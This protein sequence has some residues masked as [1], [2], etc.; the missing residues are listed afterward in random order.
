MKRAIVEGWRETRESNGWVPYG[1]DFLKGERTDEPNA[2]GYILRQAATFWAWV[3]YYRHSGD[4]RDLEPTREA[5]TLLDRHSLPIGKSRF[6]AGL[7][8]TRILSVPAGRLTLTTAL[9]KLGLL[10]DPSGAGK[11]VSADGQY[12]TVWL[13]ATALA[14]LTE[15]AYRQASGDDS[16]AGI[17]A[18][19]RDGLLALRIPG[20]GF[21]ESPVSID[22]SDYFNGEAW[23]AL[24]VYANLFRE[25]EIV[26]RALVDLDQ[27][28]MGHY[29]R[30]W[31]TTFYQWGAM[32]AAQRWRTTGDARYVEYLQQQTDV[33]LQ[34][35]SG[36]IGENLNACAPMEGLAITQGVLM[37]LG[38]EQ[39]DLAQRVAAMLDRETMKLPRFQIRPGQKQLP[40]GGDA[41]LYAPRL[42][43]FAGA[44][45]FDAQRPVVRV[46]GAQ[47]CLSALM[48]VD[49]NERRAWPR[50]PRT[51]AK[52]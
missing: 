12:A 14:L 18:A 34:R 17:R 1:F 6:Q 30:N 2:P 50:R 11:V 31:S 22:D 3:R 47:H 38:R 25:D 23:L 36:R 15:L 32:A 16:F 33:F 28:V 20:G 43:D 35:F 37:E 24:A 44:L 41:M 42:A 39:S 51:P 4:L 7:E 8:A 27:Y 52:Q 49:E 29:E 21:R 48:I 5:L 40:L 10:Y 46:D 26:S 19:W 45:L 9:K 13:G